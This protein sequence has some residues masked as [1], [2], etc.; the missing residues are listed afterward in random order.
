MKLRIKGNSLRLRVSRSEIE[1]LMAGGYLEETI[2]FAPDPEA[3][4]T[5]AL[6]SAADVSTA[7][8]RYRRQRIIVIVDRNKLQSWNE[9]DQVG[10]Y[11]SVQV[12]SGEMLELIV[13]KDFAC[14]DGSDE[15]NED[16]FANPH[17]G[18]VC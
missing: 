14:L 12:G 8:V 18:A 7:T 10:I 16:T 15:E 2:R 4:L 5:Y 1:R 17:T 3:K 11:T 9:P 13:E 6:E